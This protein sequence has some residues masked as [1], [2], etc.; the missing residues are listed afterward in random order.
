[1]KRS[2]VL[3]AA[4]L[5]PA[6][7]SRAVCQY[8]VLPGA[9]MDFETSTPQVGFSG[10]LSARAT[11]GGDTLGFALARARLAAQA[12]PRPYVGIRMQVDYSA[13]GEV[14][15][16]STVSP[17][18]LTD[19]F[20]Q[21]EPKH[22]STRRGSFRPRL[23]VGQ[24]RVGFGMERLTSFSVLQT[25][26]RSAASD[27]IAYGR[28]VGI[29]GEVEVV[30]RTRLTLGVW[31]GEGVNVFRNT[32]GQ[33]LATARLGVSPLR[34]VGVGAKFGIE[35]NDRRWGADVRVRPGRLTLEGEL[36]ERSDG[37][38][39]GRFR[40][41]GGYVFASFRVHGWLQPLAKVERYREPDGD[42]RQDD[43]LVGI[44]FLPSNGILRV[45]LNAIFPTADSEDPTRRFIT[46]A[47]LRF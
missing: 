32:D 11:A 15:E 35:G 8:S 42:L 46:Q 24:L 17:F 41:R 37:S 25:A 34:R 13:A 45:Q 18:V 9:G 22:D 20:I 28:D 27:R 21:L 39:P 44:N 4:A 43:A 5:V 36:L 14:T 29:V 7:S 33:L 10:Y 38:G 26:D 3:L 23:M 31:N 40:A 16:D 47:V 6:L 1:M 2:I 19:A 30:S 12:R